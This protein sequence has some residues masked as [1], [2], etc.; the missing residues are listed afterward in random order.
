M[1][2]E[3]LLSGVKIRRVRSII[4]NQGSKRRKK[5]N[6]RIKDPLFRIKD[7]QSRIKDPESQLRTFDLV[8]EGNLSSIEDYNAGGGV[9]GSR[10][11]FVGL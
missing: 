5:V 7:P 10:H 3:V 9:E 2:E 8:L 11:S 6:S 4:L 1:N